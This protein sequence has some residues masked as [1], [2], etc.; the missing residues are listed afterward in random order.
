MNENDLHNY[1]RVGVDH[2][3][4]NDFA[5][6][7]LDMG[8]GKTVTLLTAI[9]YLTWVDLEI[10]KTLIIAPKRVA[11]NVWTSEVQKWDHLKHLKIKVISGNEKQRIQ[12]LKEEADIYTISRDNLAWLCTF[13]GGLKLP[14]DMFVVDES[15]SFKNHSS[16]RFKTFKRVQ[17][18]FKRGVILTGTPTP[19][20][21][22]DLWAQ[23]FLLDRGERLGKTITQYRDTYFH[24]EPIRGTE[25]CKYKPDEGSD[26]NIQNKIKDICIS[27]KASDYLDLPERTDNFIKIPMTSS[28]K[29]QY[30]SFEKEKILELLDKD[31]EISAMNAASL[32][33][34]LL[35]FSNGAMYDE[36]KVTHEIHDLKLE[37]L[38]EIIESANGKPV[39]LAYTFQSDCDRILKKF[40]HLDPIKL[41]DGNDID[42]WNRGEIQ[43]MVLHPASGG[44]GLNLQEGGNTIVWFGQTWSLELY[45]QFNAR[46]H[47]QGQKE[48]VICHHLILEGSMDED[49]IKALAGKDKIQERLMESIKY[50]MDKY[51]K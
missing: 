5:G 39:L 4:K 12:I 24:T 23:I 17:P 25:F 30:S 28:L 48:K 2:V 3:I 21:L 13:F 35:Q 19:N 16:L 10:K 40:K 20:G 31:K 14:F 47:R 50:R 34:K 7:F 46:L 6:V 32:T 33:N 15:S 27:M 29:K 26:E 44:H 22:L 42:R 49:V 43:L 37:A 51:L 45:Q 36:N 9:N 18:S 1:Q 38:S 11:E 8:L 41:K